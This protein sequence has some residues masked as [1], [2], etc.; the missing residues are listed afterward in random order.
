MYFYSPSED[1]DGT[2]MARTDLSPQ[3]PMSKVD[4]SQ[5]RLGKEVKRS[6]PVGS[7]TG[8][9]STDTDC[10]TNSGV[11]EPPTGMIKPLFIAYKIDRGTTNGDMFISGQNATVGYDVIN[12]DNG[13]TDGST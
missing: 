12:D 8:T 3:D 13:Y 6:S 7:C 5:F 10:Q 1:A 4:I 9:P 2:I 11:W